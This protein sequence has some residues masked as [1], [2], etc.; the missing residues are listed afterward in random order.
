MERRKR[1][2]VEAAGLCAEWVHDRVFKGT[3]SHFC[4]KPVKDEGKCGPHLSAAKREARKEARRKLEREAESMR[5]REAEALAVRL[6]ERFGGE[7]AR[8][9][10]NRDRGYTGEVV[11][12]VAVL[13]ALLGDDDA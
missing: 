3:Q 9:Y 2:D 11:V 13:R 1:E 4:G 12:S 6:V 8:P 10:L 5:R 7:S